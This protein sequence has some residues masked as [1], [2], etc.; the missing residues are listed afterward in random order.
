MQ[1]EAALVVDREH[2]DLA[3]VPTSGSASSGGAHALTFVC[4]APLALMGQYE[5]G[6]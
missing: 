1:G 5:G 4:S 6:R 2:V 3:L